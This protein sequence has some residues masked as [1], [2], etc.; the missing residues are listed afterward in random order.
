[1]ANKM[2]EYCKVILQKISFSKPLF[3]KEYKK[4]FKYLTQAEHRELKTWLKA[5]INADNSRMAE[6]MVKGNDVH[7]KMINRSN[8]PSKDD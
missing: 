2:L 4:T 6:V 8:Q 3:K 7:N 1:M 5:R